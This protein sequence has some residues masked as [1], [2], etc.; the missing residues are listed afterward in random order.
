VFAPLGHYFLRL[1]YKSPPFLNRFRSAFARLVRGDR[2]IFL[3]A[4]CNHFRLG[5]IS[6]C[7]SGSVASAW[8]FFC[9]CR[10][11]DKSP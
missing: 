3:I 11:L 2:F 5:I 9:A 7:L 6:A 4:F 8:P 1:L 10:N